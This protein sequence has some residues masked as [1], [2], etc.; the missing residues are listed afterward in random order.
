MTIQKFIVAAATGLSLLAAL[1]AS[2]HQTAKPKAQIVNHYSNNHADRQY[3]PLRRIFR[4]L[5]RME[6]QEF[7]RDHG[8]RH[9]RQDRRYRHHR[10]HNQRRYN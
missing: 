5:R 10:H 7:F 9:Y 8:R 3:I 4:M 6:R 2:A 1:S